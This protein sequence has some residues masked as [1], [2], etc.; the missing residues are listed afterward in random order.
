[1]LPTKPPSNPSRKPIRKIKILQ[2]K[3]R[4]QQSFFSEYFLGTLAAIFA[5]LT[6]FLKGAGFRF[7]EAS[8]IA[9]WIVGLIFVARQARRL[10]KGEPDTAT[11]K[12]REKK[13]AER[14]AA[15]P[16]RPPEV[17]RLSKDFSPEPPRGVK[18]YPPPSPFIKPPK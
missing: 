6:V 2:I 4:N 18:G 10:F 13:K 8:V 14:E 11:V 1:M 15:R 12:V 7:D 3:A 17:P 9:L 16:Y 5:I